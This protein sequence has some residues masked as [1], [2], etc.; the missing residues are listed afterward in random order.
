MTDP[1]GRFSV[2][3]IPDDMLDRVIVEAQGYAVS[4]SKD[5]PLPLPDEMLIGMSP[6]AGIDAVIL[7]F[8]TTGTEPVMFSGQ[9]QASL[10]RLRPAETETTNALGI[11]EP[12]LPVDSYLP[13]R[14]QDVVVSDGLLQFDNIEPGRYRVAV[15]SG[16]KI[17]ESETLEVREN[18][19]TSATL[20][21][22][23]KHTV[24]GLVSAGDTGNR[25][26]QA[27]VTLAP[28]RSGGAAPEFP[29]YLS[30]TDGEGEFVIPE[31]LPGRYWM[32]VGA[33]GYT[34]RTLENFEVLP[35]APP[36][37]TSVTL[38]KQ[39]P[40][41]TVSVVNADGRPMAQAPLVL[42]TTSGPTPKTFFG[43]T[44]EAGLHRFERLLP[45]RYT[46]SITAPGDRTKQKNISVQLGDGEVKELTVSF[47]NSVAVSGS[48]T[49]DGKPYKGLLSFV[50]RGAAMADNL[51]ETDEKGKYA[52]DL[53]A[54][55]YTVGTPEKP[56]VQLVT[57]ENAQTQT[58]N[59]D[60]K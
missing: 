48:A 58:V 33:S 23:M 19:R 29:D 60:I 41:I 2:E 15:K 59:V 17:A 12:V 8:E 56:A 57:I 35:G 27:K 47:G 1:E 10:L 18:A 46:L 30:F 52:V 4:V 42:M 20:V 37:V 26:A 22:G 25:L 34:T 31:V 32:V 40:L 43:K 49:M 9:M 16:Q 38:L 50:Q 44:D 24:K 13:V 21:L 39:D 3:G 54:G 11:S 28:A 53:E 55:E 51:V 45:G 6:L 5:V 14:N 36:D 7:D